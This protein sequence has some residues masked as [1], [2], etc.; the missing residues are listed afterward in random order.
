VA[1]ATVTSGVAVLALALMASPVIDAC[2]GAAEAL[3]A[4]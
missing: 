1:L 2:R 3:L 4:P